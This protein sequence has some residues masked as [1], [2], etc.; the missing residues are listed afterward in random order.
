MKKLHAIIKRIIENTEDQWEVKASS[1]NAFKSLLGGARQDPHKD[2]P[3]LETSK[4]LSKKNCIQASVIVALMPGTRFIVFPRRLGS[5]VDMDDTK[6]L[7]L[8]KGQILVFRGDL[9]HAGADFD[10]EN[11]RLHCY[12]LVKG[13]E[14]KEDTTEAAAFA[15][16][17]CE[18]CLLMC[19]SRRH[20]SNHIRTCKT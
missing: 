2:F 6:V 10:E 18:N 13:I 5:L 15:S 12:V 16:Y 17:L 4:A 19:D 20:L 7:V 1:W 14:Q 3:A 11:I 8:D 9:V